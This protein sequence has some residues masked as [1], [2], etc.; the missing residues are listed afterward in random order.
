M[1]GAEAM[2]K[3]LLAAVVAALSSGVA[4]AH[5]IRGV[6]EST[7]VEWSAHLTDPTV[8][9]AQTQW[10]LGYLSAEGFEYRG[11]MLRRADV[12]DVTAWLDNYCKEK[13]LDTIYKATVRLGAELGEHRHTKK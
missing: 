2:E 1:L 6:G 13:P 10:V 9:G 11:D 5:T 8:R 12:D 3:L 7:C 4:S